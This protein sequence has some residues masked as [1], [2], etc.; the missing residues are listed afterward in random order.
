[1]SDGERR[2][3]SAAALLK[4]AIM[5]SRRKTTM[6]TSTVSRMSI[7]SVAA[8]FYGRVVTIDARKP[9]QRPLSVAG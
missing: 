1:M 4:H 7:R 9:V 6:G 8:A 3:T 5:K 2:S